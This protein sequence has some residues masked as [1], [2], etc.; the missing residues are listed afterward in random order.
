MLLV[1]G[2]VSR[3]V[4]SGATTSEGVSKELRVQCLASDDAA[5]EPTRGTGTRPTKTPGPLGSKR[6]RVERKVLLR[7]PL[8]S[9]EFPPAISRSTGEGGLEKD[10][11]KG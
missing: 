8:P 9:L 11:E 2:S 4:P 1:K 6:E 7:G 3:A 10:K 5:A